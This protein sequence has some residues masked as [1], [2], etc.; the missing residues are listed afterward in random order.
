MTDQSLT[1]VIIKELD[2]LP[3]S[4]QA[5]VLAFVRFLKIGLGD[6]QVTARQFDQA[7]SQARKIA[8]SQEITAEDIEGEIRACPTKPSC[9]RLLTST[10]GK[11]KTESMEVFSVLSVSLWFSLYAGWQT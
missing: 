3:E 9:E 7:V 5:D 11:Y 10:L 2:G 4:R 6:A 8:E 1:D